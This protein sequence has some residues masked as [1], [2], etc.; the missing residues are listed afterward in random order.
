MEEEEE[1]E[2]PV[3]KKVKVKKVSPPPRKSFVSKR[4]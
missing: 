2:E 3:P 4:A 1:I